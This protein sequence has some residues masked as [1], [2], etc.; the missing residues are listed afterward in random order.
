MN[1]ERCSFC[2]K[3][4]KLISFSCKCEGKFCSEHRYTHS[5]DCKNIIE[6]HKESKEILIKNNPLMIHSKVIKI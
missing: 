4:L 6:K 5:H 1:K 3:K 2:N